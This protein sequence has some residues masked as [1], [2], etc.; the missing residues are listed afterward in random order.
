V[1]VTQTIA[2]HMFSHKGYFTYETLLLAILPVV[3]K[4]VYFKVFAIVCSKVTLIAVNS[5]VNH[6]EQTKLQNNSDR[7]LIGPARTSV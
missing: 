1:V 2:I 4:N 3:S 6:V 7:V 5:F